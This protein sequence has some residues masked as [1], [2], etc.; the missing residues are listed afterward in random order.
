MKFR[1]ACC[2]C[3]KPIPLSQ[4]IYALDQEWQRRFPAMRGV[5]ACPACALHTPWK[6]EKPGSREY[7]DGHIAVP[8][9]DRTTDFD[10]W[11]HVRANGT[12][13]AMVLAYPEAGLLQGAEAYLRDVAQHRRVSPDITRELRSALGKWDAAR[14]RPVGA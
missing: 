4:D 8:G 14:R 12:H 3:R 10:A 5:L 2:L 11:S 7:V 6:C 13:E 9:A 1:I